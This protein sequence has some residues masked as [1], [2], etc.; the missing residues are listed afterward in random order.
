MNR[1]KFLMIGALL[2]LGILSHSCSKDES[3]PPV[4]VL[5]YPPFNESIN[6][7]ESEGLLFKWVNVEGVTSYNLVFSLSTYAGGDRQ[8]IPATTNPL[9]VSAELLK[10]KAIALG[11]EASKVT[12]VYWTVVPVEGKATTQVR[13]IQVTYY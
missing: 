4:I 3:E 8:V 2:L 9:M 1:Y 6:L 7:N 10:E 5:E 11:C 12:T 13:S